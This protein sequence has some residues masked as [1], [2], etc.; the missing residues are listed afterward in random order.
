MQY[1]CASMQG[2]KIQMSHWRHTMVDGTKFWI[3]YQ[4]PAFLSIPSCRQLI[5]NSA[6]STILWRQCDF[7]IAGWAG[8]GILCILQVAQKTKFEIFISCIFLQSKTLWNVGKTFYGSIMP[9][10]W[11]SSPKIFHAMILKK[12]V[13]L[14]FLWKFEVRNKIALPK[15]T[16]REC[17]FICMLRK[18]IVKLFWPPSQGFSTK[19]KQKLHFLNP[20]PLQVLREH[21]HMMS[22]VFLAFLTYLTYPN[23]MLCYISLYI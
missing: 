15:N 23:Q 9:T 2:Q 6:P 22:D 5:Q 4:W 11:L 8:F 13:L 1:H 18:H 16:F 21:S 20:L 14:K 7:R 19:N 3:S 12:I 10:H 17:T